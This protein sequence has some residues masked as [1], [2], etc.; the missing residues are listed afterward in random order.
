MD[1]AE[2][3]LRSTDALDRLPERASAL[4]A[5]M[6]ASSISS[7]LERRMQSCAYLKEVFSGG[8]HFLSIATLG[9]PS[10]HHASS[11]EGVEEGQILRWFYLGV[12][13]ATLQSQ[14][15]G[16]PFV[17]AMLQLL[18]EFQ[19]HFSS[20]T[21]RN[22][23]NIRAKAQARSGDGDGDRGADFAPCLQRKGGKLLYEYLLTPHVA[24]SLSGLHVAL[25]LCELLGKIYSKLIACLSAADSGSSNFLS[26]LIEAISRV[27]EKLEE[28]IFVP[29]TKHAE[30]LAKASLRRSLGK[31]DPI[32]GRVWAE[33]GGTPADFG[34]FGPPSG[35]VLHSM[36]RPAERPRT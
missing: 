28:H 16:P 5:D 4:G 15:V 12:S 13:L 1:S 25:S 18:E 10:S 7:L 34:G 11:S 2:G 9:A 33:S 30:A 6:S 3:A 8:Q 14:P 27:D 17:R 35:S 29:V 31:V 20:L 19:H 21:D 23:K 24:H 32:F 26:S 36:E 22:I